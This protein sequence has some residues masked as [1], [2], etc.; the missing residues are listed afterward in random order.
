[1]GEKLLGPAQ[2]C[3]RY[4]FCGTTMVIVEPSWVATQRAYSLAV[5]PD[6][7]GATGSRL[8]VTA[9]LHW[10][11]GKDASGDKQQAGC[12]QRPSDLLGTAAG[13]SKS[14]WQ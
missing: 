10:Q 9:T 7:A 4:L 6:V 5:G 12:S 14:W 2:T 11:A 13:S 1:M 3:K 8:F